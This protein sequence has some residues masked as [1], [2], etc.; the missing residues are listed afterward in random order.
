MERGSGT[1]MLLISRDIHYNRW[2]CAL[3]SLTVCRDRQPPP[4]DL[5][6]SPGWTAQIRSELG[7]R[8]QTGRWWRFAEVELCPWE[9]EVYF[10]YQMRDQRRRIVIT[11][12]VIRGTGRGWLIRIWGLLADV[13]NKSLN[14][15]QHH[16]FPFISPC[17]ILV[18][19]VIY[20][21]FNLFFWIICLICSS[22]DGCC[23]S[24]SYW[25]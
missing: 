21:F 7:C 15:A 9:E 22:S 17:L 16:L 24:W 25:K 6:C 14:T 13:W 5:A 11:S 23:F 18:F 4:C 10:C 2:F 3:V 8:C 19:I 20:G 12:A 1:S